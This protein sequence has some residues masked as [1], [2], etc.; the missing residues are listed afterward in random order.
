MQK[1]HFL[2][3]ISADFRNQLINSIGSWKLEGLEP[4]AQMV[5]D[6]QLVALGQKTAEDVIKEALTRV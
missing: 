6:A 2:P 1:Y 5:L 3:E 4:D